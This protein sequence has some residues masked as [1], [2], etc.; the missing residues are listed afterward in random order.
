MST[1]TGNHDNKENN[2]DKIARVTAL[3]Y[4]PIVKKHV[5]AAGTHPE[6]PRRIECT[7]N[8]LKKNGFFDK[9]KVIGGREATRSELCKLHDPDYVDDILSGDPKRVKKRKFSDIFYNKN[10]G[11]AAA[12]SAGMS[13]DA[14]D[15]VLQGKVSRA[16]VLCRPPGHHA[17][18]D[19][20]SG[21][22]F[23]GNVALAALRASEN[24]KKVL[25]FDWDVHQGDG[26]GKLVH[27]MKNVELVTIQRHDGGYFYPGTG[28]TF[29]TDNI[30][31]VGFDGGI[32]G[33]EYLNLFKKHVLKRVDKFQPDIILISAGFDTGEGDPLGGCHLLPAHYRAM[34]EA[35]LAKCSNVIAFLEG[36]YNLKTVANG[37]NAVV[38]TMMHASTQATVKQE[39]KTTSEDAG[40]DVVKTVPK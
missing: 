37:V 40:E 23:F 33:P 2:E 4:D 21:F 19:R 30:H 24:G 18:K 15:N 31:S 3:F 17:S 9:C 5:D 12:V 29:T 7:I 22:C 28:G 11:V 13:M 20:A 6:C 26:T 14:A 10:S 8:M 34:T 36:G 38:W 27:G 25:I 16:M 35:L 1:N 39:N 32:T